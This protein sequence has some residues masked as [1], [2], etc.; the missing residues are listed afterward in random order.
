M[1]KISLALTVIC[2][3]V[4]PLCFAD[5]IEITFN[6]PFADIWSTTHSNAKP[7]IED[8]VNAYNAQYGTDY[9]ETELW[10]WNPWGANY[11]TVNIYRQGQDGQRTLLNG[12][13]F[14]SRQNTVTDITAMQG[15][16]NTLYG[17]L[18]VTESIISTQVNQ[19]QTYLESPDNDRPH[20]GYMDLIL[21][22]TREK[23]YI[24]EQISTKT[25]EIITEEGSGMPAWHIN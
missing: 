16:I 17:T 20:P 10:S 19:A 12:R 1:K 9:D 25:G 3:F 18:A 22:K 23:L 21:T 11:I 15:E 6:D 14:Q 7:S 4:V 8:A 24:Q 13:N 2:L 5:T